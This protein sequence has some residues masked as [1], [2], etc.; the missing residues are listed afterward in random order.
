M[1]F[2][3]RHVRGR[4]L[5]ERRRLCIW[6]HVCVFLVCRSASFRSAS[7]HACMGGNCLVV[8]VFD[9]WEVFLVYAFVPC[10]VDDL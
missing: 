5:L 7:P 9:N 4:V 10:F 8:G 6:F 2:G 3:C 1:L